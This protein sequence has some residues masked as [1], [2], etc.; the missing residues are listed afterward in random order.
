MLIKE[1]VVLG[2]NNPQKSWK[3]ITILFKKAAKKIL[4]GSFICEYL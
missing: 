2:K 4:F 3:L 1:H